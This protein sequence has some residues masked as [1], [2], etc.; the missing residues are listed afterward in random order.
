MTFWEKITDWY[1]GKFTPC[2]NNPGHPVVFI[3]GAYKRHWTAA[4]AQVLAKFWLDQQWTIG[5]ALAVCGI[6][7]ALFRH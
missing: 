7:I 2:K 5:T 6:A 1:D 3:G 4:V